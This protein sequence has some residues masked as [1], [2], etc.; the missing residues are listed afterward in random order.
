QH[1]PV[2]AADGTG[3]YHCNPH[4]PPPTGCWKP[5]ETI[6]LDLYKCMKCPLIFLVHGRCQVCRATLNKQSDPLFYGILNKTDA[7]CKTF[8]ESGS[9]LSHHGNES[10]SGHPESSA[11]PEH[12]QPAGHPP[13]RR[14]QAH[15]HK[16]PTG[17]GGI[18]RAPTAQLPDQRA[19]RR[20]QPEQQALPSGDRLHATGT[21]SNRAIA[22]DRAFAAN[23][24]ESCAHFRRYGVS[25]GTSGRLCTMLA[26]GTWR[27]P[28]THKYHPARGESPAWYR[29]RRDRVHV[30][31]DKCRG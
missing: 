14:T 23:N 12:S 6:R 22:A 16:P 27:F 4:N 10:A 5:S 29:G 17:I 13:R 25:G 7:G 20:A 30:R 19:L 8:F 15:G 31:T 18:H 26:P 2:E 21:G 3:T 9:F 11:R 1:Q 28:G 24:A